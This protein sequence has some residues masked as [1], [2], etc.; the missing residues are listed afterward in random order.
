MIHKLVVLKVVIL[1]LF[2]FAAI[3]NIVNSCGVTTHIEIAHRAYSH[4]DYLIDDKISVSKVSKIKLFY[5]LL[6]TTLEILFL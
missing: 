3:F 2:L 5:S 1:G 6:I 4:Y